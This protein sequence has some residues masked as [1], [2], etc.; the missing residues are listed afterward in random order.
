MIALFRWEMG[1]GALGISDKFG[2][3]THAGS[4]QFIFNLQDSADT[5]I[6]TIFIVSIG[7]YVSKFQTGIFRLRVQRYKQVTAIVRDINQVYK[8]N[9]TIKHY[10]RIGILMHLTNLLDS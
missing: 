10:V 2:E 8:E 5:L 4:D 7:F 6:L 3:K 9:K 1:V